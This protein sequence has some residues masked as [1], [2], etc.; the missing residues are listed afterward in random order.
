MLMT[1]ALKLNSVVRVRLSFNDAGGN[2][3]DLFSRT[4]T[5]FY[6]T[7]WRKAQKK[8]GPVSHYP[9]RDSN[10]ILNK[11]TKHYTA[12]VHPISCDYFLGCFTCISRQTQD[13]TNKNLLPTSNY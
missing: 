1:Q 13:G 11:S 12:T 9:Y 8:V 5:S 3:R 6:W 10:R 4:L 2:G 7:N